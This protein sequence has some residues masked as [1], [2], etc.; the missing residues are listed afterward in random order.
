MLPQIPEMTMDGR[1]PLETP[2]GA[3]FV[4]TLLATLALALVTEHGVAAA[5][6]AAVP[7]GS[8]VK[9]TGRGT[10]SPLAPRG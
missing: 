2:L 10:V 3:L 5:L 9:H 4:L 6:R 1:I 7:G 8:R